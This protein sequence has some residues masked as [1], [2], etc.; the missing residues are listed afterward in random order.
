MHSAN[1]L[2][3][4]HDCT[5][6]QTQIPVVRLSV[7]LPHKLSKGHI[8]TMF[9]NIPDSIIWPDLITDSSFKFEE[10][11]GKLHQWNHRALFLFFDGV[12]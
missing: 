1:N 7:I 4:K 11:D 2:N 12:F 8:L 9:A 5:G 10:H 3:T 6:I